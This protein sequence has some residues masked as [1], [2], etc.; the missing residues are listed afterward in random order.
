MSDNDDK[1]IS[2]RMLISVGIFVIA[3]AVGIGAYLGWRMSV[4]S[5]GSA[6]PRLAQQ[7]QSLSSQLLRRD[8]PLVVSLYYPVNGLLSTGS[9]AV[10]RQQ[11]PQAQ[12]RE[13]LTAL[14][15][16]QR[17]SLVPVLKDIRLQELYLDA[18][19]TA[20]IDLVP[21]QQK[22]VTASISDE[23]LALYALVDTL[24]LNFEEIKQVAFLLDGR[25]AR[26]LAGHVDLSRKFTK[27]TDLVR[28]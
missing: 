17:A 21:A 22:D 12:A 3:L 2:Y 15:A 26:T 11:D 19:G 8:T 14:L 6:V 9:A 27:R 18:S 20:Y 13:T 23:L 4:Q 16:D 25:E 24:M 28:Q 7:G 10:K 1:G 5:E